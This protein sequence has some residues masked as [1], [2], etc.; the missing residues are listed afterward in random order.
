MMDRLDGEAERVKLDPD[1]DTARRV[2]TVSWPE[3][4]VMVKV[5]VASGADPAAVSVSTLLPVVGLV[6]HDAVTP[7]GNPDVTA[8]LTLPVNPSASFTVMVVELEEPGFTVKSPVEA[9]SQKPGT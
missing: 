8:R 1:T 3:V 5:P 4:P 6:L 2:V 9:C 7:L